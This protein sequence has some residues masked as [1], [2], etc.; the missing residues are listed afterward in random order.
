MIKFYTSLERWV[1]GRRAQNELKTVDG[2]GSQCSMQAFSHANSTICLR[3]L[4]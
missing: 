1:S 4:L 3:P 2:C